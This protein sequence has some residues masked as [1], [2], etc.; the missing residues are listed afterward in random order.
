MVFS[1]PRW[2]R[3]KPVLLHELSH[4]ASLQ[5]YGLVAAH[6]AEFAATYLRL[7][8]RHLGLAA[9]EKLRDSFVVHRVG[10]EI[11]RSQCAA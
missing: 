4:A 5:R 6:G 11:E 10:F 8:S 3:T 1:F 9:H 2:A 7:V